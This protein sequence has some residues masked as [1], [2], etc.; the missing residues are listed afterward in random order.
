M[1][2]EDT[3]ILEFNQNQKSDKALF[4][5]YADL[6]CVIEKIYGCKDNRENASS[7]KVS[8]HIP[9]GFSMSTITSF[10]SI[11]NKHDVYRDTDP[12]KKFYEFLR[13]HEMK[14]IYF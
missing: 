13:Q 10:K 4:I 14:T 8:K 2:S 11:E 3:R 7:R 1:P 12:M 6:E 5:I 9:S